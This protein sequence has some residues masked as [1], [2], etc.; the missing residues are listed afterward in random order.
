M[1]NIV[2]RY[3]ILGERRLVYDCFFYVVLLVVISI[4]YFLIVINLI[5]FLSLLW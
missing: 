5:A 3:K 4:Y 1:K 2:Y